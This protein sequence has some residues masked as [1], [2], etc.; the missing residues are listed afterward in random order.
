MREYPLGVYEQAAKADYA[1][2]RA[3]AFRRK[4][5]KQQN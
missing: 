1:L 4:H 2:S 3:E 5:G